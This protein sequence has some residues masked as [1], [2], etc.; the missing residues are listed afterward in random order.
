MKDKLLDMLFNVTEN[1]R[2]IGI[3]LIIKES[4]FERAEQIGKLIASLSKLRDKLI[5]AQLSTVIDGLE[6]AGDSLS[7]IVTDLQLYLNSKED[8]DKKLETV[9]KNLPLII[10]FLNT[11]IN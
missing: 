6:E 10:T 3:N 9:L 11:V 2:K 4:D 5:S 8:A 7:G 1:L